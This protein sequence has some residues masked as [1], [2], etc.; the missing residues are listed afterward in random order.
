MRK[1]IPYI[2][3]C[4]VLLYSCYTG[5]TV[6]AQDTLVYHPT[7]RLDTTTSIQIVATYTGDSVVLRWAPSNETAWLQLNRTGYTVRRITL[8]KSGLPLQATRRDWQV[9]PWTLAQFEKQKK[10]LNDYMLVAAQCLHGTYESASAQGVNMHGYH[11]EVNN[12]FGLALLAADFDPGAALSLGLRHADTDV[13]ADALYLYEVHS[14]DTSLDIRHGAVLLP[15]R[16][17]DV[18]VPAI[19]QIEEEEGHVVIKWKRAGHEEHFTAYQIE[20]SEDGKIYR[21]ASALPFLG[22]ESSAYPSSYFSFRH[23]LENYRPTY[24]RIKGITP[25]GTW[26]QPSAAIRGQARDKTPSAALTSVQLNTDQLTGSIRMTWKNP[27]DKD[28]AGTEIYRSNAFDGTYRLVDQGA[29]KKSVQYFEETQ[30]DTR[31]IHYYKLAAVDTAGNKQYTRVFQAAFRDT[32]PPTT[33]TAISGSVDSLGVVR[34]RWASNTE[35]DLEGYQVYMANQADHIFTNMTPYTVGDTLWQDTISLKTFTEEIYYRVA[36]VDFHSHVS[37]WSEPVRLLRPDTLRPMPPTFSGYRVEKDHILLRMNP[38]KSKDVVS[39]EF[40]RRKSGDA[41]WKTI[42]N[43]DVSKGSYLDFDVIAG[44]T[45]DYVLTSIDDAGL[46]C[47]QPAQISIR[48]VD[49]TK[50]IPPAILSCTLQEE[51]IHLAW[52]QPEPGTKSIIVYRSINGGP[53]TT[54]VILH[55]ELTYTDKTIQKNTTYAYKIKST[56]QDGQRSGFSEL[57]TPFIR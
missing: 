37:T 4:I 34:L 50:P 46:T 36:A 40:K 21:E 18:P 2:I 55:D 44:E 29:L 19:D 54:L 43:L 5:S 33:P 7:E 30:A 23:P 14:T 53:F 25:F 27:A 3:R 1:H 26:S 15:A 39:Y 11:Q 47:A 22:G 24:F 35:S 38:S 56:W 28:F 20:L 13:I 12:R 51:K 32:I 45:Y 42:Q 9:S 41:T 16:K 17:L 10:Q 6:L 31:S 57:A 49:R 52:E 8:D 48:C